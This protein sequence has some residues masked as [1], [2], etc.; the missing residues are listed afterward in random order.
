MT[1]L[2]IVWLVFLT[3]VV[4]YSSFL[5]IRLFSI[6]D[7]GIKQAIYDSLDS[8]EKIKNEIGL[9]KK[10]LNNHI[11]IS[12]KHLQKTALVRFNPFER[13]GGQQSYCL[14][15]L[16]SKNT[17]LVITFLYTKEGV[18]AYVKEVVLGK[19]KDIDLSK[20]EKEA[21]TQAQ[22]ISVIN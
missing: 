13:M 7:R 4:V 8:G 22:N 11:L 16:N 10:N 18:R 20:E 15:L 6:K 14:A 9:L 21:I 17:G 2:I 19:A 1:I 3:I 12:E 5:V